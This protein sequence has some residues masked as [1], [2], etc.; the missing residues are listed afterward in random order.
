MARAI[1][2]LVVFSLAAW[3]M[4]AQATSQQTRQKPKT[5]NNGVPPEKIPGDPK[6]PAKPEEEQ[7]KPK[8][9]ASPDDPPEEDESLKPVV[10]EF[11]PLAAEKALKAG[12]FYYKKG[13]YSAASAR[14]LE[15]S[16][17]NPGLAEAYLRLGESREK[18]HKPTE[19]I[20]A[21][22]KYVELAPDTKQAAA[23]K[24]KLATKPAKK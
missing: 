24:K 23:L 3:S 11:N 6:T 8:P 20:E 12:E 17:Y 21:Y 5:V 10:Y 15:A 7:Q 9:A 1:G 2:I 4:L 19:A 22:R 18:N 14:F 13:N 16:R